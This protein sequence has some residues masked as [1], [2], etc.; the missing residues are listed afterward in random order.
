ML[1][2]GVIGLGVGEQH[3]LGYNNHPGCKTIAACDFSEQR[4]KKVSGRYPGIKFTLSADEILDDPTIDVVSIAS[5]DNFHFEQ[6]TKA[7]KNNKHVFVEKPM[8]LFEEE[9][10][11]IRKLLNE[12]PHLKL[13]SNLILRKYPRFEVLKDIVTQGQLGKI[14][15]LEGDYLYGRLSKLTEGWRGDIPFY[16]VVSGGAVHLIDLLLWLTGDPVVEVSAFG[17]GIC[18]EGTKFHHFDFVGALLKLKSGAV[19]KVTA[20]FGCV[21]PHFHGVAVYGDKGTFKNGFE[22][23]YVYSSRDEDVKRVA[24]SVIDTPYPGAKKGDHLLAFIDSLTGKKSESL[25]TI[26]EVFSAMSVCFAIEK[27]LKEN[28]TV[29]VRYI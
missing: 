4:L 13:S 18:T 27:A 25:V 9:A 21:F 26:Q 23:G 16:S 15:Y 11:E 3:I 22:K 14:Y 8:V 19:A 5:Y 2:A 17:N 28:S 24:P 20:N 7:L 6:I 1:N 29:K 12:K 10:L